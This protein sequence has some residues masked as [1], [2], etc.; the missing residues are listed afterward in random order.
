MPY[1]AMDTEMYGDLRCCKRVFEPL[2]INTYTLWNT[3]QQESC[4]LLYDTRYT[5]CNIPVRL[6]NC[7]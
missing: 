6:A 2:Y 5:H 3:G 4:F 1:G 7:Q